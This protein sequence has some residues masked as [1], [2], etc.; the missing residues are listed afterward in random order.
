MH[1]IK[2]IIIQQ[3]LPQATR[4]GL[5]PGDKLRVFVCE[6]YVSINFLKINWQS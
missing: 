3:I 5:W 6:Q 4:L 1:D 2:F